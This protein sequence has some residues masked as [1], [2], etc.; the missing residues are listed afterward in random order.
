MVGETEAAR[1]AEED[2]AGAKQL[3][4]YT[5]QPVLVVVLVV[6]GDSSSGSST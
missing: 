5:E 6:D 2:D 3:K 4:Q 1:V